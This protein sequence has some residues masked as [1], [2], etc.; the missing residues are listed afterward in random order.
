M[1]TALLKTILVSTLCASIVGCAIHGRNFDRQ[2]IDSF[3]P[4]Q[5]T[6]EEAVAKV[7]K[8]LATAKKDGITRIKWQHTVGT[9]VGATSKM[10]IAE[11]DKDGKFT[12]IVAEGNSSTY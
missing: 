6:L 5:T 8:P 9:P 11:F 1:K 12:R 10:V 2:A 4:G 7:G 3:V